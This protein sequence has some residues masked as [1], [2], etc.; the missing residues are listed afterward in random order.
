MGAGLNYLLKVANGPLAIWVAYWLLGFY[1][2]VVNSTN[3]KA[4][5]RLPSRISTG[6]IRMISTEAEWNRVFGFGLAEWVYK[7]WLM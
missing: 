7:K 6:Y 4:C 2:A 1:L 5:P 3:R